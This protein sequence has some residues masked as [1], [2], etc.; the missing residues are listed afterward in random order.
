MI[1]VT[2]RWLRCVCYVLLI[3]RTFG[4]RL[5]RLVVYGYRFTGCDW[6]ARYVW[7]TRYVW[8]RTFYGY[9]L[10]YALLRTPLRCSWLRCIYPRC[11]HGFCCF[12]TRLSLLG[13]H[14]A[15]C[16]VLRLVDYVTPRGYTVTHGYIL[17]TRTFLR[18]AH[19]P[20]CWLLLYVVGRALVGLQILH[21]VTLRCFSTFILRL[22]LV[23]RWFAVALLHV[24]C[25]IYLWVRVTTATFTLRLIVVTRLRCCYVD[26]RYVDLIVNCTLVQVVVYVATLR[27]TRG[28]TVTLLCWLIARLVTYTARTRARLLIYCRF[29]YYWCAFVCTRLLPLFTFA[30][31][32]TFDCYILVVTMQLLRRSR[33]V[34][35]PTQLH[36]Y[37][38]R[39]C[40]PRSRLRLHTLRTPRLRY[41]LQITQLDWLFALHTHLIGWLHRLI[42]LRICTLRLFGLH[43]WLHVY[44]RF[45]ARGHA[46]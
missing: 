40:L 44:T 23:V 29:D 21:L 31:T 43:L 14:V 45:A 33:T 13:S 8:L 41:V 11:A 27:Y 26:L 16:R 34:C 30:F 42:L 25:G 2:L 7:Y 9:V 1:F 22:H 37:V 28:Y 35:Y 6:I 18:P 5:L 12:V 3:Y 15:S 4:S 46:R 17:P 36:S 24:V 20:R 19:G 10:I 39:V 32:R 38:S